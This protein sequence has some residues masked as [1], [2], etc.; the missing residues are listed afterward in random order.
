MSAADERGRDGADV[1]VPHGAHNIMCNVNF[2]YPFGNTAPLHLLARSPRPSRPVGD[3][4]SS[5]APPASLLLLGCGDLR[6]LFFTL[7]CE[8]R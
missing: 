6:D 5:P 7:L 3:G 8:E 4:S 1:L 2:F